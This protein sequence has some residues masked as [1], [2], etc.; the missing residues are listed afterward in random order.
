MDTKDIE[1]LI[2]SMYPN[3]VMRMAKFCGDCKR[4][5]DGIAGDYCY[6]RL[7]PARLICE[8]CKLREVSQP[9]KD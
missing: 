3:S 4:S 9:G 5:F 6:P 8:D 2:D 7:Q 1:A